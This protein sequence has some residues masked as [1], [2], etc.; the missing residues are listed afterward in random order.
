MLDL[1]SHDKKLEIEVEVLNWNIVCLSRH[2]LIFLPIDYH[3]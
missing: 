1:L 3:L 2:N